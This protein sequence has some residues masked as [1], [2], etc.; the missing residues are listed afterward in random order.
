M[1]KNKKNLLLLMFLVFIAV[2]T[3]YSQ[4]YNEKV[5]AKIQMNTNNEFLEIS[6]TALNK[7]E[8]TQSLR[9]VL[10]VIKKNDQNS[11]SSKNDQSGRVVLQASEK[12]DLSKT[13]IN[14]D[15]TD[16]IIILLL[17]YDFKD[18]LLGKDRV[19]IND[20]PEAEKN[21]FQNIIEDNKMLLKSETGQISIN[22]D[23]NQEAR[24]GI[25]LTGIVTENTKTKPGRDFYKLFY[26]N[27]SSKNING[28]KVVSINELMAFG[29]NTKIQISIDNTV[30]WEFFARP[31]YD[32]LK[33]MAEVAVQRVNAYFQNME[34]NAQIVRRY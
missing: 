3:M 19:V 6:G 27:Y 13:S 24:D 10:S 9:Y 32:Y 1:E 15:V 7:T 4:I 5:E 17:I 2:N 14:K 11:N 26:S 21:A 8:I 12:L 16:R 34:R 29:T 22:E 30:V 25:E 18:N 20:N 33:S 28:S 23:V 31:K